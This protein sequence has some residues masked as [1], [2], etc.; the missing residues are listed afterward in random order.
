MIAL[1][2]ND[3]WVEF[4]A[5]GCGGLPMTTNDGP[6]PHPHFVHHHDL[7]LPGLRQIHNLQIGLQLVIW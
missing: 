5:W 3:R 7:Y 2:R 1:P 4:G 6:L